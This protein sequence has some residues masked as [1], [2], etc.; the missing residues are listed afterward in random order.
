MMHEYEREIVG[1]LDSMKRVGA[2]VQ[3]RELASGV[4]FR[5]ILP[6]VGGRGPVMVRHFEP[7][8]QVVG[9]KIGRKIKAKLSKVTKTIARSKV[10]KTLGKIAPMLRNV[11]GIGP[12]L[13]SAAQK[14]SGV[15]QAAKL[16]RGDTS[17]LR[18]QLGQLGSVMPGLGG[19]LGAIAANGPTK[20]MLPAGSRGTGLPTSKTTG[21]IVVKANSGRMY[22][23]VPL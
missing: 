5:V 22:R 4:E 12:T 10:I 9:G 18:E 14:A 16:A 8:P 21:G 17:M 23:V 1:A 13:S 7:F 11:P 2:R 3:S 6:R 15:Q 19:K 20:G